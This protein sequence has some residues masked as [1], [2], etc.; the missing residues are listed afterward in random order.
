ML[1]LIIGLEFKRQALRRQVSRMFYGR[2]D[3]FCIIG[4]GVI[5]FSIIMPGIAVAIPA[6]PLAAAIISAIGVIGIFTIILAPV[7]AFL[8]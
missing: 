8:M 1:E 2:G 3:K 7:G 5:G 4:V 6:L